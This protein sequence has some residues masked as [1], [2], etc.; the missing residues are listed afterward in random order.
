MRVRSSKCTCDGADGSAAKMRDANAE[1]RK[2][3]VTFFIGRDVKHGSNFCG[4]WADGSLFQTSVEPRNTPF[5]ILISKSAL[6]FTRQKKKTG[7]ANV[8]KR[9]P[10]PLF[11]TGTR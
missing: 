11:P 2:V 6:T 10:S 1:L 7:C 5:K 3:S 9:S 8:A 4:P